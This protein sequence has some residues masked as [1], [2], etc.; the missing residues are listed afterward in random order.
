M[1]VTMGLNLN[2]TKTAS[3]VVMDMIVEFID[4]VESLAKQLEV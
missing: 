1:I 3:Q 4:S 2:Q